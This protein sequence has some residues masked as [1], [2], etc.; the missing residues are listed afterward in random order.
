MRQGSA[1]R[2]RWGLGV[3]SAWDD[4]QGAQGQRKLQLSGGAGGKS[5]TRDPEGGDR[6]DRLIFVDLYIP[7]TQ[8]AIHENHGGASG[9]SEVI[10]AMRA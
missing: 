3:C 4:G 7:G 6:H 9:G 1:R 10:Y 5:R 2:T 8:P